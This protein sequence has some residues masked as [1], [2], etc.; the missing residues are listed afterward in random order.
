M[1][2]PEEEE[3]EKRMKGC[4]SVCPVCP[5]RPPVKDLAR[6][7]ARYHKEKKVGGK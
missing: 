2:Y 1:S 7:N 3:E 4:A 5:N 6:H